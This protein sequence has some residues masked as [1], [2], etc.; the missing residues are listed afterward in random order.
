MPPR[1]KS[2]ANFRWQDKG[3]KAQTRSVVGDILKSSTKGGAAG[4]VCKF[5]DL[6][7]PTRPQVRAVIPAGGVL[8]SV[9]EAAS[10]ALGWSR[11]CQLHD[12][13]GHGGGAVLRSDAQLRAVLEHWVVREDSRSSDTLEA[14]LES[15]RS[16]LGSSRTELHYQA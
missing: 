10:K 4:F 6:Q 12:P 9:E 11:S 15:I 16:R 5:T 2:M 7:E 8:S 13:E 1:Q 3:K 14:V